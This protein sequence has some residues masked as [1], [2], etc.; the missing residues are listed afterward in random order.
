MKTG[1]KRRIV[2]TR[3]DWYYIE[4]D[5]KEWQKQ[6][7]DAAN[8]ETNQTPWPMIFGHEIFRMPELYGAKYV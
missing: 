8:D 6:M 2:K 3:S 5:K 4:T 1:T 7:D